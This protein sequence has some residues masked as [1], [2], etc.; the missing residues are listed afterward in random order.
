M[1]WDVSFVWLV[2]KEA[3]RE[4]LEALNN[5]A[6]SV[7]GHDHGGSSRK[8]CLMSADAGALEKSVTIQ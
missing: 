3:G 8:C 6:E 4:Y 7:R 1:R 5:E 2:H